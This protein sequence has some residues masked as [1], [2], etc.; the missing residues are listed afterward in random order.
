[1]GIMRLA[2]GD[3]L[4]TRACVEVTLASLAADDPAGPP[5]SARRIRAWI[6]HPSEPSQTWFVRGCGQLRGCGQQGSGER[7]GSPVGVCYLNLPDR[8]NRHRGQLAIDVHPGW[9]RRG[10]GRALLRHAARQAAENGRSILD[11]DAFAGS[12]G[13]AFASRAGGRP[14]LAD[15]RRVLVLA[16]IPA[17]HV[18][19]LRSHAAAAASGYSL[20]SWAGRTPG[21]YLDGLAGV[22]EAMNDGPRNPG[23]EDRVW[24]AQRVRERIDEQTAFSGNRAYSIAA[25]HTASGQMAGLTR[26][27]VDPEIP[28][29]GHQLITAVTR[30][31]RG[32]RLGLLL[33]TAMLEWLAS[34]EPA[35][36]R[37][38]TWNAATNEHM[39][40]INETLG[41]ELAGPLSK[42]YE[43]DV[44][45]IL[46]SA[47]PVQLGGAAGRE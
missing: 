38:V 7:A 24:D 31:N 40:A 17:G 45:D 5:M 13:D 20:V 44:A 46:G 16:K 39:I 3:D 19:A 35:V 42:T 25:V 23:R 47:E 10:I 33:K 6:E 32:H 2:A 30:P 1:M 21:E 9:R 28:E 36:E 15:A 14:G 29:W 41:F 4:A 43:L 12:P 34:A 22:F 11:A 27:A 18:A 37:I 26:V 8:E